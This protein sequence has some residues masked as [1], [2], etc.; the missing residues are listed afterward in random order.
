MKRQRNR[1]QRAEETLKRVI[2]FLISSPSLSFFSLSLS[3]L[4]FRG[5]WM[6]LVSNFRVWAGVNWTQ[7]FESMT[8]ATSNSTHATTSAISLLEFDPNWCVRRGK[9]RKEES[10]IVMKTRKGTDRETDGEMEDAWV[11]SFS[12]L[13]LFSQP[14]KWAVGPR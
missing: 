6:I 12:Y 5:Q 1:M 3:E 10:E 14:Q 9:D 7:T 8:A 4:L 11:Q 13:P 2:F